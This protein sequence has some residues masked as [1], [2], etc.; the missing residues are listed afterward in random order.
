M[1]KIEWTE[2]TLNPITG[3]TKVSPGCKNC[4]AETM[5][6][7]LKAMGQPQYQ[8]VIDSNGWWNGHIEFVESALKKPLKRKKPTM[9][10]V[11]SMSDPF[12]ERMKDEWLNKIW[13]TM[14]AC[15][16]HTFQVLTKRAERMYEWLKD[17]TPLKNVWL[18]VSVENQETAN[19]RIPYL[20]STPSMTHF[21][22]CEPL[23]A[24]IELELQGC[25]YGRDDLH[26]YI[27]WVIVGGESGQNARPCRPDWVRSIRDECQAAGVPFLFKQWGEWYPL[28]SADEADNYPD[29][30]MTDDHRFVRIGKKRAGRLLDGRTWDEFPE[31]VTI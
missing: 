6:K 9:Y 1:S 24:P 17:R 11:N 2:Q 22:S 13:L 26:E 19:R 23:L 10:F 28:Y 31:R 7:R 27:D 3:C 5:A 14:A 8:N 21:L 16:W 4:Y 20:V 15:H 18:G 30:Q 12:H 29:A 25:N